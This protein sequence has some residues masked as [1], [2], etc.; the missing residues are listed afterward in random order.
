M[1]KVDAV[2]HAQIVAGWTLDWE[3][4]SRFVPR[5]DGSD[6]NQ[7]SEMVEDTPESRL[8]LEERLRAENLID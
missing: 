8:D 4:K 1:A 3:K 2:R 6:Y 5:G 7:H